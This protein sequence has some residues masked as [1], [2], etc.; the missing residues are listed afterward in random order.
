MAVC[1]GAVMENTFVLANGVTL[2]PLGFG[3][4]IAFA[5]L[6]KNMLKGALLLY[7]DI[8]KNNFYHLRHDATLRKMLNVAP[9]LGYRL[10]DTAAAYGHSE[11]FLGWAIKNIRQSCFVVTKL[12]NAQQRAGN[13]EKAFARSLANLKTTYID[14]YL[15][16]WPQTDTYIDC[17]RQMENIYKSGRAR[18]IG[19]CNFHP[20]HVEALMQKATILPMV[21]QF[22]RH[23]LLAQQPLLA[24]CRRR[25]IQPMAYTPTG[26]M[27]PQIAQ[28]DILQSIAS[29]HNKTVPQVV[30]RWHIQSGV[31]PV[32]N[33][34]RL[35]HLGANIRIFDFEL[36]PQEMC[37]VNTVNSNF[38]LRYNPDTADF[39]K[40]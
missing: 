4:D 12:S 37:A 39:S 18:A 23:P 33:T 10:F 2:P 13:V 31:I 8:F 19:V 38:R 35:A 21:N 20:H 34:T 26:R 6:R 24:Y 5:Y 22:E 40:L 15:M 3:T 28:S 7:R 1:G 25:G 16:H 27:H 17:Y 32:F 11:S 29:R 14:L 36:S 30:L 9:G